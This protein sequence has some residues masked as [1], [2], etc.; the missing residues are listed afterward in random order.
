MKENRYAFWVTI[1]T[2]LI[3]VFGLG[4]FCG[5]LV[6][7][8]AAK[9]TQTKIDINNMPL[10][11]KTVQV[12][13][14]NYYKADLVTEENL[15][16]AMLFGLD[17]YST[18]FNKDEYRLFQDSTVGNYVGIGVTIGN[19][20][21]KRH[22]IVLQ[23]FD[24]SP[25]LRAGVEEGWEIIKING[26][27]LK[28]TD[29][30]YV[31]SLL[32]GKE[33]TSITITFQHEGIFVDKTIVRD[34][35]TINTVSSK[36]IDRYMYIRLSNFMPQSFEEM[37]NAINNFELTNSKGLILDLRRNPGGFVK[38]CIDISNLFLEPGTLA[39]TKDQ[40]GRMEEIKTSGIRFEKPLV[41]LV[42]HFTASASEVLTGALQDRGV[43]TVIGTRTFGK[44]LIQ[45]II[46]IPPF[47]VIKL[48][49]QSYLTPN[50]NE[51][52][53]VGIKPDV[54]ITEGIDNFYPL[55]PKEDPFIQKAIEIL[56]EK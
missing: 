36:T 3:V 29:I 21:S 24:K 34:Q 7:S 40:T 54:E 49:I 43:A 15:A 14:D 38:S 5:I 27:R 48:T 42:D 52:D 32:K 12:A 11:S 13:M 16:K 10:L 1:S 37:K 26:T 23:V 2:F 9:S 47:G 6:G 50:R 33:N 19:D 51:V 25:A 18:F 41:V 53:L 8:K 30:D 22:V 56:K 20:Q 28:S 55:D 46:P 17:P 35:I 4:I 31:S 39:F 44:G 45:N